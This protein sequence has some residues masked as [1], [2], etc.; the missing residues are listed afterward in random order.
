M[1]SDLQDD[2]PPTVAEPEPGP[3]PPVYMRW[4][5]VVL[6]LLATGAAV[7]ALLRWGIPDRSVTVGG[8]APLPVE[9]AVQDGARA[10]TGDR[11]AAADADVAGGRDA[12]GGSPTRDCPP[13]GAEVDLAAADA[14]RRFTEL[15]AGVPQPALDLAAPV[16]AV[17]AES[18]PSAPVLR[19]T[20]VGGFVVDGTSVGSCVISTI[21]DAGTLEERVDVV[22]VAPGR[23]TSSSSSRS[24]SRSPRAT[25]TV[26]SWTR[27]TAAPVQ[28]AAAAEVAF[29]SAG[30][31]SDPDRIAS[32]LL[33]GT[34]LAARIERIVS[35]VA[36]GPTGRAPGAVSQVPSDVQVLGVSVEGSRARVELTPTA[37]DLTDCKGRA[38]VAQIQE[39]VAAAVQD[40]RGQP[41]ATVEVVVEGDVV[42]SLRT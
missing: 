17:F 39:S 23:G 31:C 9:D 28:D 27:G 7:A 34:D 18:A 11:G 8:R 40:A 6:V 22:V 2:W 16:D 36:T 33:A 12:P 37:A 26:Q 1:T 14:I 30:G 20:R 21:S 41:G 3:G 19:M 5:F 25:W 24:S 4:W 13:A 29:Y 32:V 42:R 10:A 35:E 15:A 38:A